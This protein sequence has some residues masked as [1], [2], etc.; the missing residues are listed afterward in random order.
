[1]FIH[2]DIFYYFLS[3][4]VGLLNRK[5]D[6]NS[7]LWFKFSIASLYESLDQ[8]LSLAHTVKYLQAREQLCSMSNP[9]S[10]AALFP[11]ILDSQ[12]H[13]RFSTFSREERQFRKEKS[14]LN[15]RQ[16]WKVIKNK[17]KQNS[18]FRN[19]RGSELLHMHE[20]EGSVVYFEG[21][22]VASSWLP[23]NSCDL[24]LWVLF[25]YCAV[26]ATR[27]RAPCFPLKTHL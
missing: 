21:W 15:W 22:G 11:R 5:C 19:G 3:T 9:C 16:E 8:H 27:A 26:M 6:L 23:S 17:T 18:T 12:K 2:I 4:F 24:S 1:M 14:L 13:K 10:A 7:V 25:S 20:A